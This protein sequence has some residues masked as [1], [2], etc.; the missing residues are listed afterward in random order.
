MSL[1]YNYSF[2]AQVLLS[3][4]QQT[5]KSCNG[6]WCILGLVLCGDNCVLNW[7]IGLI[8]LELNVVFSLST[9]P[10][11][12]IHL[13]IGNCW[14]LSR[15]SVG[16]NTGI[17]PLEAQW[18]IVQ[19]TPTYWRY[20]LFEGLLLILDLA[21]ALLNVFLIEKYYEGVHYSNGDNYSNG[22]T[23]IIVT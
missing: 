15:T 16:K 4:S 9:G 23:T 21:V 13:F 20:G 18:N 1:S 10:S 2:L 17:T 19:R 8:G 7:T 12:D 3:K 11:T 6:H 5:S 22:C 14:R